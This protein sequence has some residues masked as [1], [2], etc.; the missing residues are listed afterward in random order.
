MSANV[1]SK[2]VHHM[3]DHSIAVTYKEVGVLFYNW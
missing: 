2:H 3:L 1:K